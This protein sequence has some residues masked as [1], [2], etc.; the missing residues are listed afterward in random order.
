MPR[1]TA[2]LGAVAAAALLTMTIPARRTRA[3]NIMIIDGYNQTVKESDGVPVTCPANQVLLGRA[4]SGD[5]NGNT[6]YYCGL[7]FIDVQVSAPYWSDAER[8]G[9]SSFNAPT[10]QALV[11]RLHAGDDNGPTKYATASLTAGGEP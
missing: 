9:N 6:T 1:T 11:G 10:G 7:I 2:T 8:E 3:G 4:H 5:K